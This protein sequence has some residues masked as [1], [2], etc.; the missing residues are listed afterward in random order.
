MAEKNSTII[1]SV[2]MAGSNDF[3]QRIPNATQSSISETEAALFD[4]M[5]VQYLNQFMNI[6]INRIGFTYVRSKSFTNPLAVFK[7]NKLNFGSTIQDIAP[8]WLRAHSYIDND[9]TLLKINR[10][11]AEVVYHSQNRQDRYDITITRDELR[12]AFT[13]EMGLNNLV[14]AIM[15]TPKNSDEYDEFQIMK[16]LFAYYDTNLKFYQQHLSGLPNDEATGKEFLKAAK[17]LA[18]RLQFP[19]TLYNAQKI[20]D[21]PVFVKPEELVLFVTPDINASVDVDTLALLFHLEKAEI[22]YRKILVDEFPMPNTA[23]LLTTQDFFVCHDTEYTVQSFFNPQTLGTNYFLHHWGVYSVNPF[24]PAIKFTTEAQTVPQLVTVA[25]T[26][27]AVTPETKNVIAGEAYQLTF[28]LGGTVDPNTDGIE[29]KPDSV[30]TNIS[31]AKRNTTRVD[32]Y[33]VLHVDKNET[34]GTVI[35]CTFVSTYHNPSGE[36]KEIKTTGTYTVA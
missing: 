29:V 22:P 5:N 19:S 2:W 10:P 16:Q 20:T 30:I 4:P 25:P 8:K 17:T 35:T 18:G 3:Q 7:G 9:E 31:G 26:T 11:D 15:E 13:S 34:I 32:K 1:N 14:A 36:T 21:I 12:T 24:A 23:A 6:L 27:L 28:K 33:G